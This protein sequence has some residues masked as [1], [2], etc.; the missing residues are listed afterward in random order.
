MTQVVKVLRPCACCCVLLLLT[1][2]LIDVF[3]TKYNHCSKKEPS[4]KEVF[5]KGVFKLRLDIS[6]QQTEEN[7]FV[8][9]EKRQLTFFEYHVNYISI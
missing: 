5:A 3:D 8:G 4:V 1:F 7:S 2:I 6:K 9:W